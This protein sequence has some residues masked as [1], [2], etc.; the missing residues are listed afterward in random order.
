MRN[1]EDRRAFVQ[2]FNSFRPPD[3]ADG[4]QLPWPWLYGDA[5]EVPAGNSPRQNA[6]I[7]QTQY[8][9]LQQWRDG[10]SSPT[11]AAASTTRR[12]RALTT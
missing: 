6:T 10:A 7:S 9:I 3:P 2:V 4:N 5:M 1:A 11:G 12:R 8:D